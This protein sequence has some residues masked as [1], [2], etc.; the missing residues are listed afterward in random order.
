[1]TGFTSI[2]ALPAPKAMCESLL[3]EPGEQNKTRSDVLG[4]F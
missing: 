3:V 1:M 4:K 2:V